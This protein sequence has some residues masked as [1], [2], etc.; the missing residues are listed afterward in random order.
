MYADELIIG[1]PDHPANPAA[2]FWFRRLLERDAGADEPLDG[3]RPG[4]A[5]R[6][7]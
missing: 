7:Q 4:P 3:E 5:G 6:D 1:W 2:P